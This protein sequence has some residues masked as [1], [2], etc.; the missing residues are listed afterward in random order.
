ML[1]TSRSIESTIQFGEGVVG[2]GSDNRAERDR[3]K[4]DRSEID[5]GEVGGGEVEIKK[6]GQNTSKS[7][8][9]FNSKKLSKSKKAVGSLLFL[10]LKVKR[11]FTEFR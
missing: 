4:P 11:A 9:L 8:K 7:K 6:K 1:K 5:D 10:T 3:N 2:I